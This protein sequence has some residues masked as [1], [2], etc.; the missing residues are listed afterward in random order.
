VLSS[1]INFF[2]LSSSEQPVLGLM[3]EHEVRPRG[4]AAAL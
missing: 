2:F 4:E 3:A 1:L